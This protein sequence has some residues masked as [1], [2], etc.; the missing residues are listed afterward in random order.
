MS[1]PK[2]DQFLTREHVAHDAMWICFA[3]ELER[4]NDRLAAA[5]RKLIA[6]HEDEA[7]GGASITGEEWEIASYA[8]PRI[9]SDA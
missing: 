5:L 4:E 8:L 1:T 6:S 3:R 2:T 9:D 7:N